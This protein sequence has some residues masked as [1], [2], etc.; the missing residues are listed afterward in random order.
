MVYAAMAVGATRA[1]ERELRREVARGL[2]HVVAD[3]DRDR[4]GRRCVRGL[5]APRCS[6]RGRRAGLA[7]VLARGVRLGRAVALQ[8]FRVPRLPVL[9]SRVPVTS[10]GA[11]DHGWCTAPAVCSGPASIRNSLDDGTCVC[12]TLI[13]SGEVA[14]EPV[15]YGRSA[16]SPG[17]RHDDDDA[18]AF[19]FCKGLADVVLDL[20]V[21]RAD[22]EVHDVDVVGGRSVTVRVERPVDGLEHRRAAARRGG[23]RCR[24]EE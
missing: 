24:L 2:R 8:P 12:A 23:W 10:V 15:M 5:Q 6:S 11:A 13:A 7:G 1:A 4:S 17:R 20:P 16:L 14:P 22:R 19:A 18:P 9:Y 3:D 21:G